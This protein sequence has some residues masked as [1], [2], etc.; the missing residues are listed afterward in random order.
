MIVTVNG[1]EKKLRKG[2]TLKQA[3]AGEVYHPGAC[4][5]VHLSTETVREVTNDFALVTPMGDMVL[6]LYDTPEAKLFRNYVEAIKGV[7]IRWSTKDI[8][9]FGSFPT[10]I[11]RDS[12]EGTYKRF[13]CFFSLGGNDNQTTYV[14]ISKVNQKKAFG[15]GSGVIG[16]ITV[17]RH[18]LKVLPEGY[19]ITDIHPVVSETSQDNVVVTDDLSYKL[20]EGCSVNTNVLIELDRESPMSAEQVLVLGSKGYFNV[21]E[22]TGTFMGCRDDMDVDMKEERTSV[23]EVGSV[24]IRNTGTGKGH[25]LIYKERRQLSPSINIA[26]KV[27][28]GSALV[29]R[30]AAG[31][32]VTVDTVPRR[33]MSVGMTQAA[34]AAFLEGYGLKQKR[35][36]DLSDDAIIVEQTP[37]STM[38]ALN[39]GEIETFGVPRDQVYRISIT[40]ED[41]KTVQY[42][43][44][45]TG[46]SHKPVG[47][48]KVQ[49]SY[50]GM[51]MV[52]FFGDTSRA[53]SLYPQNPFTK[54]KKGDIGV[55]NQSRPQHGLIGIRLQDS[56][57]Y[58]PT[59]EEGYGTNIVGKFLGDL[60]NMDSLDDEQIIYITEAKI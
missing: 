4:I 45:V 6:H 10:E 41:A 13:E 30:S 26:G 31:S 44:K 1:V 9:A 56:D 57:T 58:G 48:L 29:A 20:T 19:A 5:A 39:A 28:R 12:S 21:S 51:A 60:S 11:P 32:K 23:R 36:G 54:C 42:F 47:Q 27:I 49:F 22:G 59:G 15:A 52:T 55:T 25:L 14:M 8:V 38:V 7:R 16:K 33:I 2:S 35:T 24:G 34:G 50:P 40:A 18:L 53:Q 43:K 17:G 37:E 3:V 46:L